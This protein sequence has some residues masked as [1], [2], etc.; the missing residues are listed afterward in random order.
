M[1]EAGFRPDIIVQ[2]TDR[3]Q[4]RLAVELTLGSAPLGEAA[5]KLRQYMR[6]EACPLG[7]LITPEE[8]HVYQDTYS[9]TSESIREIAVVKTPML[10]RTTQALASGPELERAVLGWLEALTRHLGGSRPLEGE[11]ARV[12]ERLFPALVD[13]EV[14]VAGP[15]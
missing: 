6:D 2:G 9:A 15:R 4:L 5:R 7:L 3:P 12:E 11:V 8:A 10:L 13:A 14:M 1:G